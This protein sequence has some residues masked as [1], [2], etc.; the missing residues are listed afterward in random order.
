MDIPGEFLLSVNYVM[1]ENLIQTMTHN[2]MLT[3]LKVISIIQ[4]QLIQLFRMW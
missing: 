4:L 3:K 2:W 1:T